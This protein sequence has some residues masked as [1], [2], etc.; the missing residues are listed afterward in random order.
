[1]SSN[2]LEYSYAQS[3]Q[4]PEYLFE[5][6]C[7]NATIETPTFRVEKGTDSLAPVTMAFLDERR[8][9]RPHEAASEGQ[10]DGEICMDKTSKIPKAF[11]ADPLT[12]S[13]LW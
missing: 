5:F 4:E 2:T 11:D 8:T 1:V 10:S 7:C 9:F 13:S 12:C 6:M 3:V